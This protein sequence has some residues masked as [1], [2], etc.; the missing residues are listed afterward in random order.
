MQHLSRLAKVGAGSNTIAEVTC[1]GSLA[2][3]SKTVG[4]RLSI[5]SWYEEVP[6]LTFEDGQWRIRG[7]VDDQPRIMPFGTSPHPLF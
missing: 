6:P 7:N 5:D 3:L 1:T 4:L 2:G